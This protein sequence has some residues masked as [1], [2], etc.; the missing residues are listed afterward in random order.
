M[1]SFSSFK[2]GLTLSGPEQAPATPPPDLWY[3]KQSPGILLSPW[4]VGLTLK[5]TSGERDSAFHTMLKDTC[6]GLRWTRLQVTLVNRKIMVFYK[7]QSTNSHVRSFFSSPLQRTTLNW[8]A[9]GVSFLWKT[10]AKPLP[11][12]SD[13]VERV[14]DAES[15]DANVSYRT[16]GAGRPCPLL[17]CGHL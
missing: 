3:R 15:T 12:V 9:V 11:S 8:T 6:C 1:W 5:E 10:T 14:R 13:V 2:G 16:A 7:P 4:G 17:V